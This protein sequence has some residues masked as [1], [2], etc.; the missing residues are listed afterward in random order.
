MTETLDYGADPQVEWL[1]HVGPV[2]LVIGPNVIRE[3]DLTPPQQTAVDTKA[4]FD[5]LNSEPDEPALTDPWSFFEQILGWESRYVAG[6]PGGPALP[7]TLS[8]RVD[9]HDLVLAPNWAVR[10]LG[11][12]GPGK[13]QLLVRTATSL[14]ADDR[15]V[16]EGWEASPHQQFER[17]LRDTEIA[18]G[19]LIDRSHLRLIYAPRGETS[20]W[21]AFPLRSL[22]TVA[23]RTMLAGLKLMLG[24]ARLFTEPEERRL[25]KLLARS[26][27]AQGKVSEELAEQVLGALHELLRAFH[28][29]DPKRIERLATS[30][31][32]H[33]YEG[34]LTTLMRLVFLL[35]AEDRELMPSQRA[36]AAIEIYEQNY[37][38]RGLYARL[39]E[40]RSLN[41][42]TMDE[43]V[44]GWG[45]LLALF[46]LV[47]AGHPSGWIIGRGGKLFD[48]NAFPFLEGRND[49]QPLSSAAVLAIRDG[50]LLRILEGLMTIEARS[51]TG[52]RVRE[53]LSYRGLDVEQIGSVYETVMGFTVEAVSGRS[54]AIRGG[55]NNRTPVFIALEELAAT[56]P[57][58]RIK[59]LREH[60]DRGQ[61]SASVKSALESAK[62]VDELAAAID[63]I[64]DERGCPKKHVVAKGSPILQPTDERRRTGSHYTPRSLTEPIVRHALEPAFERLGSNA[65]PDQVLDLKVCDPAM[66]S[67]AFLVE[68]CRALAVR[69][70]MAWSRHPG[71]RPVIPPDEDEELHAR[72]LVAQRCLYGVDKNP[73]ATDLAK[74]SL[75]LATL[76]RDHE[77]TFLDHALKTGDSLVGLTPAQICATHWDPSKPGLPLFRQLVKDRT[78][79][80]TTARAEIRAA[81]DDTSRAIQEQRHRSVE[82]R[83]KDVRLIGDA[84]VA[85][86]F[87]EDKPRARE[88]KR[89]EI[90]SWL[91]GA[92]VPWHKLAHI[93][94]VLNELGHPLVPFH[95]HIEFPEVFVEGRGGFDAVIGNPP[96][97]G[98]SK[99]EPSLG[100][101]YAAWLLQSCPGAHGKS[102]LV[103][104]F[105]RRAFSIIRVG[106]TLGLVATNTIAQGETRSTSLLAILA[107]GGSIYRAMRRLPWPGDAAVVVSIVHIARRQDLPAVL[108]G[109]SV[110]RISA[111][112]MPNDFDADPNRLASNRRRAFLG[113]KIYGGGFLFDDAGAKKGISSSLDDMTALLKSHPGYSPIVKPYIGGEEIN[114]NP[115]QQHHRFV[116]DFGDAEETS[117]RAKWPAALAIVEQ[118]VKPERDTDKRPARKKYW[119][120]FGDP[121]PGLYKA[122]E[123]M[124][125][126]A[127]CAQT[128]PMH[129]VAIVPNNYVFSDKV[130]VF[131]FEPVPSFA[132]LQSRVHE[133]WM[134]LFKTT[135]K[136]DRIYTIERVFETFP[137]PSSFENSALLSAIGKAY[138]D[139]RS[140]L[141]I[142]RGEGLTTAYNLF[143]DEAEAAADVRRMREFHKEMDAAVLEAYG[144][145]DLAER[146]EPIFLDRANEDDHTYQDR[147]FWPSEFRDELIARLL[148][149]NAERHAE[150]V[151]LGTAPGVSGQLNDEQ[152][153][154]LISEGE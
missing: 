142:E 92:L 102:D 127:V 120:R 124:K 38:V 105:F 149:L 66:G 22:G 5:L 13:F 83:I 101:S 88:K 147:L 8:T 150:D 111:Y 117:V 4:V 11:G 49:D 54:L 37:S 137:F 123:G 141:M 103:S 154:E 126:V 68:A 39:V 148:L 30:R 56:K 53:R 97:L 17:L 95:W 50:A 16:L 64:V 114:S 78:T 91:G 75:W 6:A 82:A 34:L 70:V 18:I 122:V 113:T 140:A 107:Q 146:A 131:T 20:G 31:P 67:G 109:R 153:Q 73:L 3:D 93:A 55:K 89:A 116:I 69:L 136:D 42:D 43:R 96:F 129:S 33:L 112:L 74:L 58:D 62:S 10:E 52:E 72:R 128:A 121:Q 48:P 63:P 77:F 61:F 1:Y 99:I 85:A 118:L 47:H 36:G 138:H 57:K 145:H 100:R 15:G 44:G 12:P 81:P 45:R 19:V 106:G 21:L 35:Y 80:V 90:E 40:D 46:R 86:F 25:P 71:T 133:T 79:E 51:V 151:Q 65:M 134:N 27:E 143:H 7:N 84:V 24:H 104:F 32:H 119:W 28:G 108:N 87:C 98:G 135:M 60:S 59:Y 125:L 26:R 76:A 29:A 152:D 9:E 23:G 139:D 94:S 110:G 144:W 115:R 130:V 132:I 41:P 2:G 14:G